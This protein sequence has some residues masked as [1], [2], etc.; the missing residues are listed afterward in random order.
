MEFVERVGIPG[1]FN[2]F[3]LGSSKKFT[4]E[5]FLREYIPV[6]NFWG[7]AV[8]GQNGLQSTSQKVQQK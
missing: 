2:C 4:T 5:I 3:Y 6:V 7:Q 1:G 8:Q